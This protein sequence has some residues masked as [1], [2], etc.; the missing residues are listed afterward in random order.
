MKQATKTSLWTRTPIA[1]LVLA[2]SGALLSGCTTTPANVP[3]GTTSNAQSADARINADARATLDRLYRVAAGSRDMV[4]R[5][6][7]VLVFP[8]VIGGA[9]IIGAQHGQG[10]LLIH[11]RNAG[12]YSTTGASIGFQAGA[13]SKAVV[14]VFNSPAALAKFQASNGWTAGAD[15]V[16]AVGTL[17]ANG[18]VDSRTA[19]E[20]VV[21]FV[22]NNA[23]VEGGVSVNGSKITKIVP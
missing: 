2:C 18:S 23:G 8:S 9:F 21:S 6:A 5:S 19:S 14:Y 11:G 4:A 15:A 3:A 13:G 1:L 17:G 20:P 16:V 7:G 12:Y 22:M 10:A